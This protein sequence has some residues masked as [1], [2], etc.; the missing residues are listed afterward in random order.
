[1]IESSSHSGMSGQSVSVTRACP[2]A[3]SSAARVVTLGVDHGG[4]LHERVER[5]EPEEEPP[6]GRERLPHAVDHHLAV[7]LARVGPDLPG[8]RLVEGRDDPE[9]TPGDGRQP[10]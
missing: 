5:R 3:T 2:G 6:H 1:M 8:D 9:L 7:P 4:P 10:L